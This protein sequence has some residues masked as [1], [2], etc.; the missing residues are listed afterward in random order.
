MTGDIETGFRWF[1]V[2]EGRR[3]GP[4]ALP[5]LVALILGG[6]MPEDTLIWHA[7]LAEWVKANSVEEIQREL[8]PPIP[9]KEAD[10]PDAV[11]AQSRERTQ[12]D[13]L[14]EAESEEAE[15]DE[16]EPSESSTGSGSAKPGGRRRRRH[17]P[18]YRLAAGRRRWLA[19]LIVMLIVVVFVLW[20]L[21]RRFNEVPQGQVIFQGALSEVGRPVEAPSCPARPF[22]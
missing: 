22:A 2:Q 7:G 18:R 9:G 17:R 1:Y 6:E 12:V 4:L 14:D 3:K 19:P 15:P 21:L 10:Q 20:Y 11:P 8:P 13:E 16:T 5:E